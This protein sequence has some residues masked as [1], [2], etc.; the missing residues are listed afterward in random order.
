MTEHVWGV[1]DD[2]I[3]CV[4]CEALTGTAG[5]CPAG[6]VRETLNIERDRATDLSRKVLNFHFG[7]NAQREKGEPLVTI[8]YRCQNEKWPCPPALLAHLIGEAV[9]SQ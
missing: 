4:D 2:C 9:L 3:R 1:V 6:H 5:P 8:C 7:V